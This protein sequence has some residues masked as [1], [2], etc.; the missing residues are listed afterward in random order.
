M[1]TNSQKRLILKPG[2][3][4]WTRTLKNQDLENPGTRETWT[5]KSLDPKK[6]GPSKTWI[7]KNME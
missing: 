4:P 3:G 5:L 1:E 2:S 6:P 7:L